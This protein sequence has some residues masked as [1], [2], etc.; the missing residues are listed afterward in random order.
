MTSTA[1]RNHLL[2]VIRII[3]TCRESQET[4]DKT[5]NELCRVIKKEMEHNIP[6]FDWSKS[7]RKKLLVHKPYWNNELTNLWRIKDKEKIYMQYRKQNNI[8]LK[9]KAYHE[10]KNSQRELDKRVR[11]FQRKYN[12]DLSSNL[13]HLSFN[14]PKQLWDELKSLGPKKKNKVPKEYYTDDGNITSET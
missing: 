13:E 4:I 11:F 2:N 3:E 14:S 7:S 12:S 9:Q 1:V 5:Y 8:V 10:Y 6:I